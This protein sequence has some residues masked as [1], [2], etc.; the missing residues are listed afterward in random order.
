MSMVS[1]ARY[2]TNLEEIYEG[3]VEAGFQLQMIRLMTLYT[4]SRLN[5]SFVD[6]QLQVY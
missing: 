5:K 4:K 2:D 6:F 1:R 3:V